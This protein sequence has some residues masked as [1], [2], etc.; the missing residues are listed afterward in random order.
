MHTFYSL[1]HKKDIT[2][3]TYRQV[4]ETAGMVALHSMQIQENTNYLA[5]NLQN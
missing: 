4:I 2:H 5:I 3:D 1:Y